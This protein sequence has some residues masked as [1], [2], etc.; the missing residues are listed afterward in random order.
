MGDFAI[1]MQNLVPPL[2]Q[3]E[4]HVLED[5]VEHLWQRVTLPIARQAAGAAD[6][7]DG[8]PYATGRWLAA[9]TQARLQLMPV[10]VDGDGAH[11]R[12]LARTMI[13]QLL[14]R[15]DVL[16]FDALQ[17]GV[18]V[19]ATLLLWGDQTLTFADGMAIR[20]ALTRWK[21]WARDCGVADGDLF[22][23]MVAASNLLMLPKEQVMD[24]SVR[25]EIAPGLSAHHVHSV[26]SRFRP[27]DLAP[28]PIPKGVLERLRRECAA[29]PEGPNAL[30]PTKYVPVAETVLLSERLIEPVSLEM[31]AESDEELEGLGARCGGDVCRFSLLRDVW[32]ASSTV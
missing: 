11:E 10:Q 2:R 7:E 27:D 26:L 23:H 22:P 24:H 29:V 25:A 1:V 9:L 12:L 5:A 4:S 28:D 13:P 16:L 17:G 31:D 32:A 21:H 3:L 14:D 6:V 18:D 8:A 19:D 15:M 20:M 30:Q